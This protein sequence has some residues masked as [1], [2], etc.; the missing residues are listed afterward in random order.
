MIREA[1][2]QVAA[3]QRLRRRRPRAYQRIVDAVREDV[4]RRRLAPGD[5]LPNE[6]ALAERFAVSRLAVREALRILELQGLVRVEHGFQGGAFVADGGTAAVTDAL[7]TML[8]L[9]RLDRTELYTARRHLEPVVSAL[10]AAHRTAGTLETLAGNVTESAQRLEAGQH[11]F[12]VN[13]EFHAILAGACGNRILTLLTDAVLELLG[14]VEAQRPSDRS[15]NLE[16]SR[17]HAAILDAVE[18]RDAAAAEGLMTKHL[19]WLERHFR[20]GASS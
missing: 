2:A 12:A 6:V 13:L 10:A 19:V 4:F 5:R 1:T 3:Q 9:E 18:R 16:A 20:S 7:E 17:A 15:A 14:R 8:R 11:A